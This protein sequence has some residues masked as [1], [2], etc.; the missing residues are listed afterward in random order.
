[1][2]KN[3]IFY[4][5]LLIPC[6]SSLSWGSSMEDGAQAFFQ[7]E[8]KTVQALHQMGLTATEGTESLYRKV[9]LEE[10]ALDP[11]A[12]ALRS[13][14]SALTERAVKAL[15]NLN[16]AGAKQAFETLTKKSSR[17][18]PPP[19]Q[20]RK[21]RLYQSREQLEKEHAA[22]VVDL[23]VDNQT[24]K[25]RLFDLLGAQILG[26]RQEWLKELIQNPLRRDARTVPQLTGSDEKAVEERAQ[27]I[28]EWAVKELWCMIQ[29]NH[30]HN[31]TIYDDL[32]RKSS[33]PEKDEDVANAFE[34]AHQ[35]GQELREIIELAIKTD[36]TPR[37]KADAYEMYLAALQAEFPI[38]ENAQLRLTQWEEGLDKDLQKPLP[39]QLYHPEV[40]RA[41]LDMRY[42]R[43][44][45]S[46][47]A[48]TLPLDEQP[49][50]ILLDKI[51]GFK[52]L[53]ETCIYTWALEKKI[54]LLE[55]ER[56]KEV[57]LNVDS[58]E[59]DLSEAQIAK[60]NAS[61]QKRLSLEQKKR[62]LIQSFFQNADSVHPKVLQYLF[63]RRL[64]P[65]G[66]HAKAKLPVVLEQLKIQQQ[67]QEFLAYLV[68]K[69]VELRQDAAAG[70]AVKSWQQ[71]YVAYLEALASQDS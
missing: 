37:F 3:T 16:T 5:S 42:D 60:K 62:H 14:K 50:V 70:T 43:L 4:L 35:S 57:S 61:A 56:E 15:T 1:M 48:N 21:T 65:Y 29:S 2:K 33:N 40:A 19:A 20:P 26:K 25:N 6:V 68:N 52:H 51:I 13:D 8:P 27:F 28:K 59:E 23:N 63:E 44:K 38:F 11:L 32:H 64:K 30:A 53:Q 9:L 10:P 39:K 18:T 31:K 41:A 24:V 45:N 69:E 46:A 49:H 12:R 54:T 66:A 22:Q 58:Y 36:G 17:C 55:M 47:Q 34:E 67:P 71:A 7:A